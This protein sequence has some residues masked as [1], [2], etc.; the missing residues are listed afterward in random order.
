MNVSMPISLIISLTTVLMLNVLVLFYSS[1]VCA[2]D[3]LGLCRPLTFSSTPEI[4][5][6]HYPK[7]QTTPS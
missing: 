2:A 1:L 7:L 5:V 4:F 3:W 6:A